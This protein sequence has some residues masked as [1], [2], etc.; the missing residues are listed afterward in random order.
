[1]KLNKKALVLLVCVAMLLTVTVSGTVAFLVDGSGP[2]VNE[3][4]PASVPP[5]IDE[6]LENNTKS[7]VRV[8]NK[9][10]V[11]AYIRAM[12]VVTWQDANGNVYPSVPVMGQDYTMSINEGAAETQWTKVGNFYYYNSKV[13]ANGYTGFLIN[14]CTP[15]VGKE[16]QDGYTLHV[17]ILAQSI[18]ADGMGANNA[19]EAFAKAAQTNAGK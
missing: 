13:A 4:V 14:S 19:Q 17:E 9:G 1:M 8:Q 2:V 6:K 12:I 16:P 7:E 11:D 15:V 3:F 5:S 10:N 18:Q